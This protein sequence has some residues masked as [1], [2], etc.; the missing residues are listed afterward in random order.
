MLEDVTKKLAKKGDVVKFSVQGQE[1]EGKILETTVVHF[2]R[3]Y[4]V[5][6]P[7][8]SKKWFLSSAFKCVKN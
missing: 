7:D 8:G 4:Y 1:I 6:F 5:E 2:E 3:E